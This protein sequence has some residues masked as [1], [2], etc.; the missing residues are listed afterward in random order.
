M[1]SLQKWKYNNDNNLNLW[2]R[3]R[4][5]VIAWEVFQAMFGGAAYTNV[6]NYWPIQSAPLMDLV[7]VRSDCCNSRPPPHETSSTE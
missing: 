7:R 5:V 4:K 2:E 1:T 6:E 3:E